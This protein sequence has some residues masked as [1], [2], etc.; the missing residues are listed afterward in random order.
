LFEVTL[1]TRDVVVPE[2]PVLF[3]PFCDFLDSL[4]LELVDA[5]PSVFFLANESRASQDAQVL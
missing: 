1:E 3:R 5:L 4:R 2:S